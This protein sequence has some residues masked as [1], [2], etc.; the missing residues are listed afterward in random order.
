MA[1]KE[2]TT[3]IQVYKLGQ[4]QWIG[5]KPSYGEDYYQIWSQSNTLQLFHPWSTS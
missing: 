2:M 3:I 1:E 5:S 4:L